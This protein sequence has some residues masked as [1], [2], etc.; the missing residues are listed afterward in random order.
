MIDTLDP[1]RPFGGI[2]SQR[3]RRFTS[4]IVDRWTFNVMKTKLHSFFVCPVLVNV[5]F[6]DQ[7]SQ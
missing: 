3:S 4:S 5:D 7:G 2:R 6:D 1:V